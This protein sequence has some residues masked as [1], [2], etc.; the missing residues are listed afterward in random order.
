MNA[1]A[2]MNAGP[3]MNAGTQVQFRDV[4]LLV[5]FTS[6][7]NL[8]ALGTRD[9]W[10]PNEPIYGLAVKEMFER[11]DWLVPTVNGQTFAE[12][13]ILYFWAAL[14]SSHAL[15]E[16]SEFSVRTPAALAGV[17]SVVLIYLWILPYAGRRRALLA[18]TLMA[19]QY[20]V[21][22]G[23]RTIQM[24]ILVLF[25]TLGTLLPLTRMLDHGLD[26]K[27]AWML[28][29]LSAGLGFSAKGPV[30]VVLPALV[31]LAYSASLRRS[32]LENIRS[33]MLGAVVGLIFACPWYL[34]LWLDGRPDVLYEVLIRQNFVRF[35]DAWDHHQPWWYYL[36]Y[37]WLDFAPWSWF[38]PLA[39]GLTYASPK[40]RSLDRLAW[41][42]ILVLLIFFSLSE[43]K[44]APYLLPI[45]P[46]VACLASSVIGRFDRR[47]L[48]NKRRAAAL[49]IFGFLAF[50]MSVAGVALISQVQAGRPPLD[51]ANLA[52][53]GILLSAVF[54]TGGLVLSVF[55]IW[56]RRRS[57]SRAGRWLIVWISGLYLTTSIAAYPAVNPLKSARGFCEL[58]N[59]SV[60][61]NAS[62]ASYRFWDWRAGYPYYSQRT[63]PDIETARELQAYWNSGS[64]VYLLVEGE[65]LDEARQVLQLGTP[66]LHQ[67][68]G[69]REAYLFAKDSRQDG[70]LSSSDTTSHVARGA[71]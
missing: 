61:P 50:L 62:L 25:F 10:N 16:V 11:Q 40:E 54:L 22:W 9:L 20:G 58:M 63:I 30:V 56:D 36:K 37:F 42:W 3:P 48:S 18:A 38:V 70:G 35:V 34:A 55:L 28:A 59:A 14:V 44:R 23:S 51:A 8:A 52:R 17:G 5:L 49:V 66:L 7:L 19:T 39:A 4:A 41:L 32:P 46:A 33:I 67:R 71:P 6:L 21:F 43:S 69:S 31:F 24:D 45:A 47:E 26:P 53:A 27:K 2:P 65:Y 64:E 68:I 57:Q 1:G 29:G 12:K 13:P 15:G 60:A